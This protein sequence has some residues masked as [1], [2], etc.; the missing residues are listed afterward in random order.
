MHVYAWH[1]FG[2]CFLQWIRLPRDCNQ[3]LHGITIF[4]HSYT[5]P[6]WGS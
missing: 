4:L 5:L 1:L 6:F 3:L 2:I